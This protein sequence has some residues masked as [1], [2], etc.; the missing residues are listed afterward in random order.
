MGILRCTSVDEKAIA[1][2]QAD[3]FQSSKKLRGV[4]GQGKLGGDGETE[5]PVCL[6]PGFCATQASLTQD[7]RVWWACREEGG[8]YAIWLKASPG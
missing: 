3:S 1:M 5:E 4:T 7:V 2:G 6:R 8:T